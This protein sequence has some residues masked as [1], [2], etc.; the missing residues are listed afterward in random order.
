MARPARRQSLCGSDILVRPSCGRYFQARTGVSEPRGTLGGCCP[1][2]RPWLCSFPNQILAG[3]GQKTCQQ[4]RNS[5]EQHAVFRTE[6]VFPVAL[7]IQE[8]DFP[9]RDFHGDENLL[10]RASSCHLRGMQVGGI[11]QEGGR[12]FGIQSQVDSGP[13]IVPAFAKQASDNLQRRPMERR[14]I[15]G[16]RTFNIGKQ[17]SSRTI[18]FH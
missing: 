17:Q 10:P 12:R 11:L 15:G 5:L 6:R 18:R 3:A 2:N 7:H 1:R 16:K 14:T 9:P 4:A 13:A 8:T